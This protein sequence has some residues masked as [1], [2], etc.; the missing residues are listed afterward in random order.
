ME[1]TQEN[2]K[3][4]NLYLTPAK[5]KVRKLLSSEMIFHTVS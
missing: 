2:K 4:T 5:L 1:L 3:G